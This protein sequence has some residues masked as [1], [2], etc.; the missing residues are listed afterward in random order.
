MKKVDAE[1]DEVEDLGAPVVK[2]DEK[3][4]PMLLRKSNKMV[5]SRVLK[6]VT[7]K[8]IQLRKKPKL[9][10]K[11]LSQKVKNLKRWVMEIN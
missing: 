10:R 6:K 7:R 2:G 1:E 5:L 4:V 8:L 11:R 9:M 3:K